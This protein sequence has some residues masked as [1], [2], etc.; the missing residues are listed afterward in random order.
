MRMWLL[1]AVIVLL[2]MVDVKKL[3]YVHWQK[4]ACGDERI[5]VVAADVQS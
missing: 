3:L 4:E 2:L 1:L 5:L